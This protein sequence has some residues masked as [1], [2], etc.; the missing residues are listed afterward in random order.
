MPLYDYHCKKCSFIFDGFYKIDNRKDPES[1]PCPS[2]GKDHCIIQSISPVPMS[3]SADRV[4]KDGGFREV[5]QQVH[6]ENYGSVLDKTST[7]TKL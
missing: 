3:Y 6:R 2:C 1:H 5:L 7:I 4:N